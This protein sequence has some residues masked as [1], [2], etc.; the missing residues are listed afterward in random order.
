MASRTSSIRPSGN[1]VQPFFPPGAT[2]NTSSAL[3]GTLRGR[4]YDVVY[5]SYNADGHIG[6]LN[7]TFSGTY[8]TGTNR[9]N[10]FTDRRANGTSLSPRPVG[11]PRRVPSE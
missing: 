3:L 7:M 5:L 4:S 9:N 11:V 6:R 2:S 10:I 8:A 1:T